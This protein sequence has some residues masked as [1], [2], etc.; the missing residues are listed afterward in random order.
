MIKIIWDNK[1]SKLP[2]VIESA[3]WRF[4]HDFN[5]FQACNGAFIFA[6]SSHQVKFVGNSQDN[7]IIE[8]I[9]D[10]IEEGKDSG[11]SLVKVLYTQLDKDANLIAKILIEKYTPANNN[12]NLKSDSIIITGT[13]RVI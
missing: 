3:S 11:A 9:A 10:A 1:D 5:D 13:N 7:C 12:L 4:I 2:L 6:N 8:A